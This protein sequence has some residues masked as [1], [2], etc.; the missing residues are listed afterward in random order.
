MQLILNEELK[1]HPK[2]NKQEEEKAAALGQKLLNRLWL[3]EKKPNTFWGKVKFALSDGID[4]PQTLFNR[5][6]DFRERQ[7][8][9]YKKEEMQH[10]MFY[11]TN[12][13]RKGTDILARGCYLFHHNPKEFEKYAT[14]PT[15]F[16]NDIRQSTFNEENVFM[17]AFA[18]FPSGT[19]M[20]TGQEIQEEY[21]A[22]DRCLPLLSFAPIK[23][24]QH[25][26][27]MTSQKTIDQY[28]GLFSEASLQGFSHD[29]CRY[30]PFKKLLYIEQPE[31]RYSA[32]QHKAIVIALNEFN[33]R[34]AREPVKICTHKDTPTKTTIHRTKE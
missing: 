33:Q 12:A 18:I 14:T 24:G 19:M 4:L 8:L 9:A 29:L 21:R 28:Q 3:P 23:Y 32:L 15:D 31:S 34:L 25:P 7:G 20:A 6:I 27:L 2:K 11:A 22:E 5:I 30:E 17:P 1:N 10:V 16:D 26:C 13:F